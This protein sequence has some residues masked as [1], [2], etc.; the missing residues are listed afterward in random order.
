MAS[1]GG[2]SLRFFDKNRKPAAQCA[3]EPLSYIYSR[4]APTTLDK[5]DIGVV[6]TCRLGES[7]LGHALLCPMLFYD[8]RK[9]PGEP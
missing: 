3:R 7:F 8:S 4:V 1:F 6:N 9:G 2:C 5:T